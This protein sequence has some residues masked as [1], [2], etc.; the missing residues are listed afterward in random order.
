MNLGTSTI[1]IISDGIYHVD[2]GSVFG[3]IPKVKWEQWIKPDRRNRV[4]LA[5]NSLVIKTPQSNIL[6]DTGAGTKRTDLLKEQYGLNG[7]KCSDKVVLSP[8]C[9]MLI[10]K[11]RTMNLIKLFIIK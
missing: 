1:N 8:S 9:A 5:L 11:K 3:Q 4:K 6:I 7:N 10:P 2:G